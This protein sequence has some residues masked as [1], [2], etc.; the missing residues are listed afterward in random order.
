MPHGIQYVF[1]LLRWAFL[2]PAS[3]CLLYVGLTI[4]SS[5][6]RKV[7]RVAVL[8]EVGICLDSMVGL[9]FQKR[10]M[11]MCHTRLWSVV[12]NMVRGFGHVAM[13]TSSVGGG[14]RLLR[15]ERAGVLVSS[16]REAA[17]RQFHS[18]DSFI[19]EHKAEGF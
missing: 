13:C 9:F 14:W 15:E 19:G 1:R 6:Y 7:G 12:K 8:F 18:T 11:I 2:C 16:V 10:G 3:S 4:L 5:D 17:Y